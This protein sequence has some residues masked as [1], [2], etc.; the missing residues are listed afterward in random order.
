MRPAFR[1]R[2]VLLTG[3]SGTI[4]SRIGPALLA[5]GIPVRVLVHRRRPSW[6]D[7][8]AG[9]EERR[10][11]VLVPSSLRGAADGCDAV[12]HA[13]AR[14]GFGALDRDRQHRI[15]VEGTDAMLQEASSAGARLFAMLGYTGTI[16]ERS[17][18]AAVNEETPPEG[19]YESAY[20]RTMMEAEVLTLE[21]NRPGEF[22]TMV[23]SPGVLL[24]PGLSS[25]LSGLTRLYLR[26]ELPYRFLDDVW[27]AVSGPRDVGAGV[28]A[29]LEHGR[30]GRRYFLTGE[31]LRM[32]DYY[33]LLAER[34]G[35]PLPRRRLPDLLVEELG[36]L[37]PVLP[38]HSF[39]RQVVLPRELV[40]HLRRLAPLDNERTRV[41]LGF[42]P[43]PIADLVD[44]LVGEA[45]LRPRGGG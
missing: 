41:E 31:S 29:A 4:G 16:Q 44:A 33:A 11:D 43:E 38:P 9:V 45:G 25:L 27:L 22:R 20:V 26:Q 13:A 18:D 35:V 34:S 1:P 39:L 8:A 40:L 37:A 24:G 23:A 28:V 36:L 5:A 21:A 2:R 42:T 12:V 15:H 19:Q 30:G 7:A 17:G 32:R 3:A 6:L 14:P 10:G